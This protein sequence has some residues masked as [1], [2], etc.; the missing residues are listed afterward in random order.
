MKTKTFILLL[1]FPLLF[2]SCK[3]EGCTDAKALNF[4]ATADEDDGTCIYCGDAEQVTSISLLD[5]LNDGRFSSP[6]FEENV[7][8]VKVEQQK[9]VGEIILQCDDTEFNCTTEITLRNITDDTMVDFDL[10]ISIS[11]FQI[12]QS[13]FVTNINLESGADTLIFMN[14]VNLNINNCPNYSESIAQGN[15]FTGVYEE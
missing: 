1:L 6:Y 11:G 5:S 4:D 13:F 7:L 9:N 10:E 14:E 2:S 12:F 8:E 3:E 15:I